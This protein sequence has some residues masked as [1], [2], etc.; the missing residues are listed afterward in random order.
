V[1]E[2]DLTVAELVAFVCENREPL[3]EEA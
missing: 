1:E 2:R 3:L